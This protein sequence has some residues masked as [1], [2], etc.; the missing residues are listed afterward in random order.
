M[1]AADVRLGLIFVVEIYLRYRMPV[2]PHP[3]IRAPRGVKG[4]VPSLPPESCSSALVLMESSEENRSRDDSFDD[5]SDD[6]SDNSTS[7]S[8]VGSHEDF[9]TRRYLFDNGRHGHCT[10]HIPSFTET[11]PFP[12]SPYRR[13]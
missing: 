8:A 12:S 11:L 4:V 5:S 7:T 1:D 2:N 13:R 6:S 9:L 10:R 3:G